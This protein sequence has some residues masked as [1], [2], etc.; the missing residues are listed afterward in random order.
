MLRY[1]ASLYLLYLFSNLSS[2]QYQTW[3]KIPVGYFPPGDSTIKTIHASA[4]LG[5]L[6]K[7]PTQENV[8]A[9]MM[10]ILK[11]R[12]QVNSWARHQV[13]QMMFE[14]AT[15]RNLKYGESKC[16]VRSASDITACFKEARSDD[17]FRNMWEVMFGIFDR[18]P[19]WAKKLEE[20]YMSINQ[21]EYVLDK[22]K[23]KKRTC[24]VQQQITQIKVDFVKC[25]NKAGKSTHN[26]TVGISRTKDEITDKTKFKKR[27][28]GV[29][30]PE[31]ITSHVSTI[32]M[33]SLLFVDTCPN[34]YHPHL[35]I[36]M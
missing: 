8:D 36:Y 26:K 9:M 2:L 19:G 30:R 15:R 31:Y 22:E 6:G 11:H 1:N 23:K 27:I 18:A 24:C 14:E 3:K 7:H 32:L 35:Q 28:K 16:R 12:K 10:T 25:L 13:Q 34:N 33:L 17:D 20:T 5:R 4:E 21:W 29:F